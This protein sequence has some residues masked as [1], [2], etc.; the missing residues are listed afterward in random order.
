MIEHQ[1]ASRSH[2]LALIVLAL[3]ASGCGG[4]NDPK[5]LPLFPVTG[6]VTLDGKPLADAN[7]TFIPVGG[8]FGSGSFARSGADGKYELQSPGAE[9]KPGAPEG[10][11]KV[12]VSREVLPNGTVAPRDLADS[13]SA[14]ARE[15]LPPRYSDF[16]QTTLSGKVTPPGPMTVDL[17][18]TSK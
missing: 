16:T 2:F 3:F 13:A 8:T 1:V 5:P 14:G 7:I 11:Y 4:S 15:S 9:K 12:I 18:L 17:P 10:E 6:T